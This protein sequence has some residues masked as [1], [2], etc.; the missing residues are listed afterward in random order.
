MGYWSCDA[1][2]TCWDDVPARQTDSQPQQSFHSCHVRTSESF[3]CLKLAGVRRV[4]WKA[5]CCFR[6]AAQCSGWGFSGLLILPICLLSHGGEGRRAGIWTPFLL[7]IS[8]IVSMQWVITSKA[9]RPYHDALCML[10]VCSTVFWWNADS[11][12]PCCLDNW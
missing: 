11:L 1:C 4:S 10:S 2:F 12:M 9:N 6:S 5:P 7:F 8:V 3:L